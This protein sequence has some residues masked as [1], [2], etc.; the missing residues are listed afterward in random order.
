VIFGVSTAA[1]ASLLIAAVVRLSF[2]ARLTEVS[3][4]VISRLL[5]GTRMERSMP[6]PW[7]VKPAARVLRWIART[8]PEDARDTFVEEQC[9]NVAM[10][11]SRKERISY[12]ADI[13][14]KFPK[15]IWTYNSETRR[16]RAR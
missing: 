3:G 2:I 10:A 13:L 11:E 12:L 4:Q 5:I 14:V 16:A 15:T 8:L 9:A 6:E 7:A 1:V